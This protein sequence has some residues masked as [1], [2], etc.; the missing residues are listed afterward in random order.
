M[1]CAVYNI[2]F[3]TYVRNPILMNVETTVALKNREGLNLASCGLM[4]IRGRANPIEVYSLEVP[5]TEQ[6]QPEST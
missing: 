1:V 2:A 4:P 6:H 5:I 3:P